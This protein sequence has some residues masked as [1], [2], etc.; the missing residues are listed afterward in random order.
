MITSQTIIKLIA[1]RLTLIASC[2]LLVAMPQQAD[3]LTRGAHP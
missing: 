3:A 1:D 2:F